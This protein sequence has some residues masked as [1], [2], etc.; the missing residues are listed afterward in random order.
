MLHQALVFGSMLTAGVALFTTAAFI[1]ADRAA[2]T[3]A[4]P[5]EPAPLVQHV[6]ALR[7]EPLEPLVQEVAPMMMLPP[8]EI[9]GR[10]RSQRRIVPPAASV[11]AIVAEPCSDWQDL[12]PQ[13]VEAGNGI[14]LRRVRSLCLGPAATS[15]SDK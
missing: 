9:V 12:G 11:P 5:S 4:T 3:S 13:R 2:F 7:S 6:A 15:S 14:G 1:Q 8:I 10:K